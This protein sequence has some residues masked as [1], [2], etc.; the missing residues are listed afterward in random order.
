MGRVH[1]CV[2][3]WG[4][5]KWC[6]AGW[7]GFGVGFGVWVGQG[8]VPNIALPYHSSSNMYQSTYIYLPTYLNICPNLPHPNLSYPTT[9][10]L[11]LNILNSLTKHIP[12]PTQ[13]CPA[14][15]CRAVACPSRPTWHHFWSF[16]TPR[17]IP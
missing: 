13:P 3:G 11:P 17:Q 1:A 5:V 10:P 15:H 12:Y 7:G 9:T 4:C 6:G 2:V 8:W 16:G 14:M